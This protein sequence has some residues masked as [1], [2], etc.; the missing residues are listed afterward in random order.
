[1]FDAF[2]I[3][4]KRDGN[5]FELREQELKAADAA[6]RIVAENRQ[7]AR[8]FAD[9]VTELEQ[10]SEADAAIAV[11]DSRQTIERSQTA[12]I[13]IALVSLLVAFAIGWL[14]VGRG[15]VRRLI[16]LRESM[17]QIVAGKLDTTI[18]SGGS[19]EIAE[20]AGALRFFADHMSEAES[21]APRAR[22]GRETTGCRAQVRDWK[23][24]RPV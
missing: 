24:R 4:G 10:H 3:F 8:L 9:Q 14:Y 6:A 12:L 18:A 20:M 11:N 21:A 13:V 15:V 2:L 16:A 19:D 7:V 5:V 23:A 17:K 1:M 22:R